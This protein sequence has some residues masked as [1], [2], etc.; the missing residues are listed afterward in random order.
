MASKLRRQW[1]PRGSS[2]DVPSRVARLRTM[3]ADAKDL[4]SI[5]DYFITELGTDTAFMQS[6]VGDRNDRLII[7]VQ[8]LMKPLVMDAS[9]SAA[10]L[11]HVPEHQLWHGQLEYASGAKAGII[12]FDDINKGLCAATPQGVYQT[13]TFRFAI[14]RDLHFPLHPEDGTVEAIFSVKTSGKE[15]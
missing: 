13:H 9:P 8:V 3:M 11:A 1:A 14:P 15:N 10:Y 6:G 5:A 7:F 4:G 2:G 12:Y